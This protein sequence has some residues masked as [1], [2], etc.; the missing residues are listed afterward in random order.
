[1]N[2]RYQ[3]LGIASLEWQHKITKWW[4]IKTSATLR[5]HSADAGVLVRNQMGSVFRHK[6]MFTFTPSFSAGLGLMYEPTCRYLD[7]TMEAVG[8]ISVDVYKTLLK[9]KM[10]IRFN[11]T[12]YRKERSAITSKEQFVHHYHNLTRSP[13]FSLS[14][15]YRLGSGTKIKALEETKALQLYQKIE[16]AK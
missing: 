4:N 3:T 11:S 7:R 1:M 13:S 16:D 6:S 14:I 9:G 10:D 15:S 2:G 5:S 8:A 12:I